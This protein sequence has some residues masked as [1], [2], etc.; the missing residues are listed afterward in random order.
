MSNH[1][2]LYRT[3]VLFL[4][5]AAALFAAP[6]RGQGAQEAP[7]TAKVRVLILPLSGT[8]PRVGW[9]KPHG[10][11]RR[12]TIAAV[13]RILLDQG[14]FEVVPD[15]EVVAAGGGEDIP[16]W[17]WLQDDL[18]LVKRVGRAVRADFAV[19]NTREFIQGHNYRSQVICLNL[20]TGKKFTDSYMIAPSTSPEAFGEENRKAFRRYYRKLFQGAKADLLK[21]SLRKAESL[22]AAKPGLQAERAG[23]LPEDAFLEAEPP[24]RPARKG[25]GEIAP[26]RKGARAGKTRIVVYDFA[27]PENLSVPSLIL[28]EALREELLK[29][30]DF[31]LVNR[32]DLGRL[33]GEMKVQQSGM[34][35]EKQAVRLGKGLAAAEAVTG[36]LHTLGNTYILQAKRT[37]IETMGTL[38]IGS[39]K[40]PVGRE[41]ELLAQMPLLA[42]KLAGD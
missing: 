11:F 37:D 8:P 30:G 1:P 15:E 22:A 42:K 39:L 28:T 23:G 12:D 36:R 27:S 7:T 6:A 34:I 32:E 24:P 5:L 38:S 20:W 3:A 4:C 41:E 19:V 14:F 16:P 18:D 10:I 40:C 33:A 2:S 31:V 21:I 29:R 9:A 17:R 25:A 35:D 13:S 26:L